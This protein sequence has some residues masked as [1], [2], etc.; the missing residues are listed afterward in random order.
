MSVIG[1]VVG[2]LSIPGLDF[3]LP[4]EILVLGLI[5]GL[6]YSLLG[7]GLTLVYKTSRILNFAHGEMG[8]L[9]ALLIPVFVINHRWNFWLAFLVAVAVAV[10]IGVLM[11]MTVIRRLR[12]ASR[13]VV[14]V[15]TIGVAQLLFLANILIPKGG[16]LGGSAYPTPFDLSATIGDVRLGPGRLMILFVVPLLALGLTWFFRRSRIGRASRA[17]AEDTDIAQISGVPIRRVSMTVWVLAGLLAGLSAILIGP[18]RPIETQAALGPALLLRALGAAM[19]GGLTNLPAVFAGGIVIG[20]VEA[21]VL[22]NYPTG[23]VLEVVL[24]GIILLSFLFQK[25]L[26]Q[27]VRGSEGSSHSLAGRIAALHPRL[28]AHPTV[29]NLKGVGLVALTTVAIL[30][31]LPFSNSERFF[32]AGVLIFAVIGLSLVVLTGFAGQVSLGQFAFVAVG[33]AVGGRLLQMGYP[34]LLALL[35]TVA[36]GGAVALVV[37]LPALRIRG[38]FLA[39]ATLG[40]AVAA[41]RWLFN[42]PWLVRTEG[43]ITSLRISRPEWFGI[44]FESEL[45]YYWLCLVVLIVVASAVS[46]LRKSGVGRA[47]LAVRDNEPSASTFSLSPRRVKLLAFMVSGSIAA[48]GGF[49]YGGLLVNFADRPGTTTFSPEASLALV[50]MV[51]F[52]G[53][54]TVTGAILGAVWVRGMPYLFGSNIGLLSSGL[55]L[56]VVLLM[57]PGGLAS[58][59]FDIRDKFVRFVTGADEPA[60]E[61]AVRP[62]EDEAAELVSASGFDGVARTRAGELAARQ[63]PAVQDHP[64]RAER[65]VVRFGG[66]EV[67][68]GVSIEAAAGEIVGLM[69]PNGA[70]KTTLFDVLSGQIQAVHG[71]VYLNGTDVSGLPPQARARLGLGRTFQQARLFDDLTVL[72]AFKVALEREAPTA[73]MPSV[74]G[75]PNHRRA[76]RAKHLR[77]EECVELLGLE[78]YAHRYVSDL[79]TGTR[80]FAELG[81]VVAMGAEVVLLDEPTAG[82]AQREVERFQ[83]V[84]RDIRDYLGATM[85]VIDHDVPMMAGLVDRLYVLVSG[86]IIA[87]GPPSILREDPR[88]AEAYLGGDQRA[89]QRSGALGGS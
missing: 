78:H 89:V 22:W 47:F 60:G 66:N 76:E 2:A 3:E 79:S 48:L 29:Q 71:Q 86:E 70:G 68:S 50:A 1:T 28:A 54:T 20:L 12:N 34:H 38:L 31:P 32:L 37:G 49:F 84:L 19:L 40:F 52:G 42:Q 13:L 16:D 27:A 44:D 58:L 69:G 83:P 64:L 30:L 46:R 9:P 33:A 62:S 56:L 25:Q 81:C 67:L 17:V 14:L 85:V 80:R 88:V 53:V 8:A 26:R 23:G 65:I 75:L 24:F 4:I 63:D 18:T 35:V 36:V 55:G 21:L 5:T 41:S 77:A 87:S 6:T 15:A 73:V 45:N 51:V 61:E 43:G 11:E 72:D 59:V 39:V 10:T 82:F 57:I 74:L 7:L